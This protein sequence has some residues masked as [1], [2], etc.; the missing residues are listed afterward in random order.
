MINNFFKTIHNKYNS[1]Y[2]FIFFLRYLLAIFFIS[3][4]IFLIIPNFFNYEKRS[5]I[6]KSYL[7]K[8]YNFNI[9]SHKNIRFKSF[10]IPT[11]DMDKVVINTQSSSTKLYVENLELRPKIISIYNYNNFQTNKIILKNSNLNLEILELKNFKKNFL[12]QN[13]KLFLDN[14]NLTIR[15]SGKKIIEFKRIQFS[16][17]GYNKNLIQGKVFNKKFKTRITKNFNKINFDLID[18]GLSSELSFDANNQNDLVSG[19]FKTKILNTNIKFNFFYDGQKLEILNSYFRNKNISFNND[20][21]IFLKPFLSV[22]SNFIIDEINVDFFK[23]LDLEK[24]LN[25]KEIIKKINSKNNIKFFKK[26]L[27]GNLIDEIN[28]SIDLAYGRLYYK[29]NIIISK[30]AFNCEGNINLLDEY[31][32]LFFDCLIVSENTQKFL[33]EFS[34]NKKYKIKKL[35]LNIQGNLNILNKKI[36]FSTILLNKDYEATDEDLKYFKETFESFLFNK[37]FLEIFDYKKI[38]KFIFEIS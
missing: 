36:N 17:Y 4:V 28:S 37:S 15:N 29:K 5:N 21:L 11:I 3:I 25:E 24:I 38:K 33:K 12:S 30:N 10:P 7:L 32:L 19:I 6:V 22:N 8:N 35:N 18:T 31:P 23:K 9:I 27:K 34:I 13:K 14:L 1:F 2:K 26:K 20:S 16:N